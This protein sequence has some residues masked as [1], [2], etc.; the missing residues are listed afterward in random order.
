MLPDLATA[1]IENRNLVLEPLT[2]CRAQSK[3]QQAISV[4]GTDRRASSAFETDD[5][6]SPGESFMARTCAVRPPPRTRFPRGCDARDH[7]GNQPRI[8][9]PAGR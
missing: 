5:D 6:L 1:A 4:F 9:R 8:A 2:T 3:P 7:G